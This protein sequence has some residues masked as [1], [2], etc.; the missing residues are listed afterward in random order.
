MWVL[1]CHERD[2]VNIPWLLRP[3]QAQIAPCRT[4]GQLLVRGNIRLP[5]MFFEVWRSRDGERGRISEIG[6]VNVQ[7]LSWSIRI[8]HWSFDSAI[9]GGHFRNFQTS[10]TLT[11]DRIVW[12]TVVYHSSTSSYTRNIVE[13]VGKNFLWTYGRRNIKTGFNSEQSTQ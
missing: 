11:F 13:I 4:A 5:K 2:S 9:F 10:V 8:H 6:P 1:S 7:L 3:A 12:H